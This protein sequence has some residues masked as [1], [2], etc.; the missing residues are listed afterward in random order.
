MLELLIDC[1]GVAKLGI[2]MTSMGISGNTGNFEF[3]ADWAIDWLIGG[4]FHLRP[5]LPYPILGLT[6]GVSLNK[7][8]AICFAWDHFCTKY[9]TEFPIL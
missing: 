6:C 1:T 5:A 2:F 3:S 7:G 9:F 4:F 8:L